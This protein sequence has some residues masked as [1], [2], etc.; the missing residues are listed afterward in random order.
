[1]F[2]AYDHQGIRFALWG[3]PGRDPQLAYLDARLLAVATSE[4]GTTGLALHGSGSSYNTYGGVRAGEIDPAALHRMAHG[5]VGSDGEMG[6]GLPEPC[7]DRVGPDALC[8]TA[9][10][11]PR[12]GTP[13][14]PAGSFAIESGYALQWVTWD[15][16]GRDGVVRR[17]VYMD[18]RYLLEAGSGPDGRPRAWPARGLMAHGLESVTPAASELALIEQRISELT[19]VAR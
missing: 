15:D 7:D 9:A 17:A 11:E 5:A 13:A 4:L 8:E 19:G 2:H 1:M 14:E 10:G 3:G 18:D 12:P 6:L 16:L